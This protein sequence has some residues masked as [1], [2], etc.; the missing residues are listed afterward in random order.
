MFLLLCT[1]SRLLVNALLC[2]TMCIE[3]VQMGGLFFRV[4]RVQM[5]SY[6]A[7]GADVV[8]VF[9]YCYR[10]LRKLFFGL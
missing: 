9:C 8:Q 2:R 7:A 10:S 4:M 1:G 5:F 3:Q 6:T